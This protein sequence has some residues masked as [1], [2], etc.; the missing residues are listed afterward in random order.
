M[1][2]YM[3]IVLFEGRE[4]EDAYY[5][6]SD[7]DCEELCMGIRLAYE[8]DKRIFLSP[9]IGIKIGKALH[10]KLELLNEPS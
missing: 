8:D 1:T 2:E 6:Y 4:K 9:G 5:F 7:T 3:L 10:Y